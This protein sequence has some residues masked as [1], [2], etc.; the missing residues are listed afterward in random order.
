VGAKTERV[1]RSIRELIASGQVGP[2]GRLPSERQLAADLEAGRTTIRLVLVKLMA[3]GKIRSE[4]GRGYFITRVPNDDGKSVQEARDYGNVGVPSVREP[5]V[6]FPEP[7]GYRSDPQSGWHAKHRANLLGRAI[8]LVLE[9]AGDPSADPYLR[10][11]S[12]HVRPV[13]VPYGGGAGRGVQRICL[14]HA[15]LAGGRPHDALQELE[16]AGESP[17]LSGAERASALG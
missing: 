16:R 10:P 3:E 8:R 1:E 4:H 13:R 12:G 2:G 17:A 7:P 14:G 9:H 15:L 11:G 5:P 6:Q